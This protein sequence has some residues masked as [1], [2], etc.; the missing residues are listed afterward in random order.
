MKE[1]RILILDTWA[2]EL[3]AV[4]HAAFPGVGFRTLE[5]PWRAKV[6]ANPH[7]HGAHVASCVLSQIPGIKNGGDDL[8]VSVGFLPVFDEK[9]YAVGLQ[10]LQWVGIAQDWLEIGSPDAIRRMNRSIGAWD[11]DV[12]EREKYF[13]Q[14]FRGEADATVA[15]LEATGAL[16]FAAAGNSDTVYLGSN[17]P[18]VEEDLAWPQKLIAD[19]PQVN[20]IGACDRNGYPGWFSSDGDGVL[21]MFLGV[22][23]LVLDPYEERWIRAHGTSFASPYACG[24]S[25][26]A[27]THAGN[28]KAYVQQQAVRMPGWPRSQRHP[29]AGWGGMLPAMRANAE[30]AYDV[31]AMAAELESQPAIY[32]D[33]RRIDV[34]ADGR[35]APWWLLPRDSNP[36]EAR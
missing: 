4:F 17:R 23:A 24:D 29:K 1:V 25:V 14:A 33:L 10:D 7:P 36:K 35:F 2:G 34:P 8:D 3:P 27:E 22:D 31:L 13:D 11:E 19:H 12:P 30:D 16:L 9:G 26:A 20:V 5:V 15:L 32:H 28:H 6:P 18:E 21:C